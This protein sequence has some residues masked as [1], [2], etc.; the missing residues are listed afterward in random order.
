MFWLLTVTVERERRPGVHH[1]AEPGSGQG[2]PAAQEPS[3]AQV[4]VEGPFGG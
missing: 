3:A 1:D 2:L 4:L